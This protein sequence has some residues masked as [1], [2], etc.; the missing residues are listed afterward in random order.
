MIPTQ[1]F[2][3]SPCSLNCELITG[4][5]GHMGGG[6]GDYDVINYGSGWRKDVVNQCLAFGLLGH[7]ERTALSPP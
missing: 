3:I 1:D 6:R 7:Y 5:S 4:L 2:Q